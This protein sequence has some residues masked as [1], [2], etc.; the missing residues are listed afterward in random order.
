MF[1]ETLATISVHNIVFLFCFTDSVC[2]ICYISTG[3]L[4]AYSLPSLRQLM[5]VDFLPLA[6]LRYFFSVAQQKPK[7]IFFLS[8]EFGFYSFHSSEFQ[9]FSLS[10]RKKNVRFCF[11]LCIISRFLFFSVRFTL[12]L[13]FFLSTSLL[14][15]F[16]SSIFLNHHNW[17]CYYSKICFR[18][19][20]DFFSEFLQL[21][22][23]YSA[24]VFVF[25]P[26]FWTLVQLPNRIEK[27][28]RI[29]FWYDRFGIEIRNACNLW[30]KMNPLQILFDFR[31][32]K[33]EMMLWN[34][35]NWQK[36]IRT[37][38]LNHQFTESFD[39]I[40]NINPIVCCVYDMPNEN[41]FVFFL[42][43]LMFSI[44]VFLVFNSLMSLFCVF[45]FGFCVVFDFEMEMPRKSKITFAQN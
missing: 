35:A 19:C 5:D 27:E 45:L 30:S 14:L 42:F 9:Y 34:R 24:F 38:S 17:I 32:F 22:S 21:I 26:N 13:C 10:V 41:L 2:L 15:I 23:F 39:S 33:S 7:L 3:H 29:N 31:Q 40:T 8:F 1:G 44:C 28:I 11:S 36:N 18:F 37:H 43:I 25:I 12:F 20:S 6:D 16:D 4:V